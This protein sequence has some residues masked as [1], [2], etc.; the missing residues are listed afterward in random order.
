MKG[1]GFNKSSNEAKAPTVNHANTEQLNSTLENLLTESGV[2]KTLLRLTHDQIVPDPDQPRKQ[3]DESRIKELAAS[4][5][6]HGQAQPIVVK[7]LDDGNYQII[8]GERRWRAAQYGEFKL[9]AVLN[10]EL[11]PTKTKV[12]QILENV[13]REEMTV[14]DTAVA[15]VE[16]V[17][18]IVQEQEINKVDA[19]NIIGISKSEYYRWESIYNG[20]QDEGSSLSLFLMHTDDITALDQARKLEKKNPEA[21]LK[22]IKRLNGG[23]FKG[24]LRDEIQ[25]L[26]AVKK[27]D[28]SAPKPKVKL[29][30]DSA[31]RVGNEIIV[32]LKKGKANE[33]L[34]INAGVLSMLNGL[35]EDE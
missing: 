16:T 33:T 30:F 28:K 31:E 12:L 11:S 2:P 17:A 1:G 5:K 35:L 26:G 6:E 23:S 18:L 3:F 22:L 29:E 21:V 8:V 4:I 14:E 32:S 34:V 27:G 10:N 15:Y 9:D 7:E 19:A 25:K 20:L 13:K 24:N